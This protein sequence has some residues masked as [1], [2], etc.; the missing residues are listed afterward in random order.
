MLNMR[1]SRLAEHEKTSNDMNQRRKMVAWT[2]KKS[3][4]KTLDNLM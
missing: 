4:V 3:Q 2:D 1:T